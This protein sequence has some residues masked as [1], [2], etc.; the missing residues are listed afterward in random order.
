MSNHRDDAP[1]PG[2]FLCGQ[3]VEGLSETPPTDDDK[4]PQCG[5]ELMMGFGLAYG[6][7]GPYWVCEADDCDY[8]FK[9]QD[10]S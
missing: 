3:P 5:V 9:R 1:A 6:G 4:C 2:T 10:Q 8:V 7:Y